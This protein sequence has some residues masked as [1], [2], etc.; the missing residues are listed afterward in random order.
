MTF[1]TNVYHTA[2]YIYIYS[3]IKNNHQEIDGR[4]IIQKASIALNSNG[5]NI[6]AQTLCYS[7]NN[8]KHTHNHIQ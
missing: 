7:Q 2:T 3:Y 1:I 8:S 4:Y 6:D 5:N